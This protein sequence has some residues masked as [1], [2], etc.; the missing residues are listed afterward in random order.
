MLMK[1]II[2]AA[3]K[4]TRLRPLSYAI[5]KPLLPVAGRPVIEYVID[6]LTRTG[7]IDEIIVAVSYLKEAV[8]RYFAHTPR[9]IAL[10]LVHTPGWE[11]GGDLK[12]I[13]QNEGIREPVLVAYGDN[14][15]DLNVSGLLDFHD[16]HHFWASVALFAVPDDLVDRFGIA[17]MDGDTITAFQEKPKKQEVQSRLANAGYY[18]LNEQAIDALPEAHDKVEHLLFP[19]LAQQGR[20]GGFV[21]NVSHWIDIGTLESYR[22][23]NRLI[24]K[25][26]Q[27]TQQ[28]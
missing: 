5:P 13:C 19:P 21:S 3:G 6:N 17:T 14:I 24:E 23:A 22:R 8:E 2:L 10:R 4:G 9:D 27:P 7:R 18:I 11:T 26:I 16:Q 1:A 15:T 28:Q 12:A 20:L 25:G